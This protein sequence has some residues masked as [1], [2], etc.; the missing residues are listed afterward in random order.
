MN[1]LL[2]RRLLQEK[3]AVDYSECLKLTA[4]EDNCTFSVS[5]GS[6]TPNISTIYYSKERKSRVIDNWTCK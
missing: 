3:N 2:R 1:L 5:A 4:L 6:A